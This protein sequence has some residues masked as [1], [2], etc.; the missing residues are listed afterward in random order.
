MLLPLLTAPLAVGLARKVAT[1]EGRPLNPV[2]GATAG[3]LLLHSVLTAAGLLL[4]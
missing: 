1:V 3:A 4:G 2:L